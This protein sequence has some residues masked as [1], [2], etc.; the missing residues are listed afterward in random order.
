MR[1]FF[2]VLLGVL[3]FTCSGGVA[4]AG[5]WKN[6][7]VQGDGSGCFKVTYT[8]KRDLSPLNATLVFT[9]GHSG[10]YLEDKFGCLDGFDCEFSACY[11]RSRSQT[12]AMLPTMVNSII[13]M[14]YGWKF[15]TYFEGELVG[16]GRFN[17]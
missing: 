10:Y 13:D 5:G 3:F 12:P 2:S 16:K 1:K 15:L 9:N 14:D 11:D 17:P 6:V 4:L 8:A 7:D